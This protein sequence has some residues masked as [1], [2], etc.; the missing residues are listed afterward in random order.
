MDVNHIDLDNPNIPKTEKDEDLDNL[1]ES[2]DKLDVEKNKHIQTDEVDL[3][4]NC[5]SNSVSI[6]ASQFGASNAHRIAGVLFRVDEPSESAPSIGSLKPLYVPKAVAVQAIA[7]VA[8]KPIDVS[9]TLDRHS[10]SDIVGV[11]T[12]AKVDESDFIVEGML[13]P[14][15]QQNKVTKILANK[16][17]L[18]MSMNASAVGYETQVD[19]LDV[20]YISELTILGA[21]ILCA[22]KATYSKTRLLSAQKLN[23]HDNNNGDD[24]SKKTM[25]IEKYLD[26]L[27]NIIST[28]TDDVSA[29]KTKIQNIESVVEGFVEKERKAVEA[30]I[31]ASKKE[32]KE[33]YYQSL[34]DRFAQIVDEKI[35]PLQ[36]E[37]M[38]Q[39]GRNQSNPRKSYPLRP[40]STSQNSTRASEDSYIT[41]I[42][43]A[44][45]DKTACLE[46]M[47]KE[48]AENPRRATEFAAS[49]IALMEEIKI[50]ETQLEEM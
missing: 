14:Y 47:R 29:T 17:I 39:S 44:I 16:Q 35:A 24:L 18:G 6:S 26:Q 19:G 3:S 23:D 2:L 25:D 15:N 20:F 38:A 13:W 32:E 37:I 1:N 27:S 7:T 21:N 10:L 31:E 11:I 5:I 43:A 41:E 49:R 46:T 28:L 30:S 33:N 48:V 36:S 4:F 42:Q 45:E 40:P 12:S 34:I 8:N 50:L 9:E 22:D